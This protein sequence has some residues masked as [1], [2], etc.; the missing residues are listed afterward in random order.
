MALQGG[1]HGMS[2]IMQKALSVPELKKHLAEHVSC[3]DD[4]M[5]RTEFCWKMPTGPNKTILVLMHFNKL[6]KTMAK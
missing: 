6:V 1:R 4:V 3:S 2:T 5:E